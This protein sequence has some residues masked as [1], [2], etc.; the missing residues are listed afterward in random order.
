MTCKIEAILKLATKSE[1]KNSSLKYQNRIT[2]VDFNENEV[3]GD[4]GFSSVAY[5]F[6]NYIESVRE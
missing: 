5:L 2:N 4:G 3:A 6:L 1:L